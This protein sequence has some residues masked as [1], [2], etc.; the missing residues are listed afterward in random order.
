MFRTVRRLRRAAGTAAV[1]AAVALTANACAGQD[2]A[3]AAASSTE[4]HIGAW[5]PLTGSTA[6]YGVPQRAGADAYFKMLNAQGGINGRKIRWTVKDNA[7]DPQQTV[8]IAR[9]LI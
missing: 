7:A 3:G 8:Q 6:A 1:L 5:L 2:S 4:I 9:E